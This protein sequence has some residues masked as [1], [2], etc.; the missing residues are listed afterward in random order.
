MP[1]R[2]APGSW[3]ASWGEKAGRAP[4]LQLPACSAGAPIGQS[5]SPEAGSRKQQRRGAAMEAVEGAQRGG[6]SSEADAEATVV[7]R[8]RFEHQVPLSARHYDRDSSE[9]VSFYL[10]SLEELLSWKPSDQDAFNTAAVPLAERRPPLQSPRPRSLVCHDMMGGYLQDRFIQGSD[11]QDFY[12]FYHWQYIDI[13]VYFTHHMFTLP[14]VCWTNTAHKH[15][16]SVLG[17]FIT[18]RDTGAKV[19][20]AFLAGEESFRAVADQMVRVAQFYRFDGWLIN[21]ENLLSVVAVKN[22]PRF[23]H[24]LTEQLKKHVPGGL[25]LWY[26]S[27]VENGKLKWQNELN[28]KNRTFFDSCDG[29]FTNYNWTEQH[30][31]RM[32][33]QAAERQADVYV[34]V[35]VFARGSVVGGQF[36]TSKSLQLIRKYGFSAAIFAPGWVY[37]CLDKKNFLQ[38]QNKFWSLLEKYLPSHSIC[39]LPLVTSFCIGCGN[40]RFSYGKEE[41]MES[42]CNLIAQE[43]QPLFVNHTQD[44]G[45]GG[46]VRTQICP[47]DAWHGGSSL[48][49]EGSIPSDAKA[50]TIRLFS[51]QVPSP[52]KILLSMVYK[53]EGLSNVSVALEL[54]TRD[55]RTCQIGNISDLTDQGTTHQLEPGLGPQCDPPELGL[56][57]QMQRHHPVPGSHAFPARLLA[58]CGQQSAGGW[59]QHC[60]E[61]QL[62]EC[63]L[64]DLSIKVSR[65]PSSLQKENFI[66]RLGELRVLDAGNLSAPL[67]CVRSLRAH[68][69]L[70]RRGSY[71]PSLQ[72]SQLYLSVT[73]QWSYP[74]EC[75]RQFRVYGQ[76][77][78]C[79]R[80]TMPSHTEQPHLIGL[81]HA[82]IYRV[83]DLAVPPIC[84]SKHG[85]LEFLV[86]PVTKEGFVTDRSDWGRLVLEYIDETQTQV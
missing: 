66:C 68:H 11:G 13:F 44:A 85:R 82:T 53:L 35:D 80:T 83:V 49:V 33:A 70:W 65:L 2:D 61:L 1:N 28:E 10:S 52:P 36:D 26:D 58:G 27:V 42:W 32:S 69:F 64:Q 21:I 22:T 24:Y 50:V 71:D 25:V 72:A 37:E 79:H 41:D 19:C 73:L 15:G 9:P 59:T 47:K 39:T 67:Q 40:K 34:G 5:R 8:I 81:A 60:Y 3:V 51:L 45:A 38:N 48:L 77:V 12:T 62:Q 4:G 23:L 57:P 86:Q 54:T 76:G 43:L 14:P 29:I 84:T 63:L 55:R 30:L 6:R 16:V 7:Q 17:T 56:G 75:V 31:D 74:M 20:E 46:W 18:E 78:V